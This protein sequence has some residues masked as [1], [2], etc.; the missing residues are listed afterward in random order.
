MRNGTR[1]VR[2]FFLLLEAVGALIAAT[3]AIRILPFRGILWLAGLRSRRA[4]P[5]A[6]ERNS[7]G[8][9]IQ[10][11]VSACAKRM[12]WRPLCFPQGLAAQWMLRRRGIP[13]RFYY[14]AMVVEGSMEAHVW[15]CDGDWTVVGGKAP[16]EMKVLVQ[17]PPAG[18]LDT[19]TAGL[20][21]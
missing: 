19:A 7:I 18:N 8:R 4:C 11:A 1:L 2:E 13:S 16:E 20:I 12:P 21:P 9:R 5:R 6:P 15:V 3:I 10:W 17:I 14:G